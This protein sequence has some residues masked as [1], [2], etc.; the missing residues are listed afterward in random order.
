MSHR[1]LILKSSAILVVFFVVNLLAPVA[2]AQ[3]AIT[4][5]GHVKYSTGEPVAGATVT[6]TVRFNGS[7]ISSETTATDAGG[8]YVFQSS[9]SQSPCNPNEWFFQ[10]FIAEI[11]DDEALPLSNT[12]F[13]SGCA[14]PGTVTLGDLVIVRPRAITL[15]GVVRD[16]F[17]APVQGLTI[18]MTRTKYDFEPDVVTTATTTTDGSGHYQFD[19]WSRCTVVEDFRASIG[20]Y[21]F[22]GG[23]ATSGC[24]LNSNDSLDFTIDL[25]TLENA[26][27]GPC[28]RS[29]GRPV[30]V[31]NGNVFLQ[32]TDYQLPGIGESII[33]ARSYNSVSQIAGLF[34][35]SWSSIYDEKVSSTNGLL[36]LTMPDGRV[37]SSITP[38]F[39][40]QIAQNGDNTYTVTFKSGYVHRFNAIGKLISLTD[41]NGNQ[42]TLSYDATGKLASIADP[43]GR[44]VTVETNGNGRVLSLSDSMGTIASYSYGNNDELLSVRYG[45]NSG[46]Q[47]AYV[48]VPTGLALSSVTDVLG[49]VI[50]RHDYDTRGRAITSEAHTGVE[51]Y[52]LNYVSPT[53]TDVT[54]ALGRT[55]KF[56]YHNVKGTKAVTQVEG[57]CGCGG[58]QV[59]TWTYDDQL[60]ITSHTNAMGEVATYAYDASGN[61]INATGVLGSSSFTYNQFG[62][63]LTATDAM[64]GVTSNS[65]DAAGNLLSVTDALNN[66]TTFTYDVRGQLLTMNNALGK[67]TT[68]GY[69]PSGNISQV[70]DAVDSVTRF[71]YNSRGRLTSITDPLDNAT[72]Y[73]YDAADRVNK[74]ARPDGTFVAYTYDLAGRRTRFTDA[75]NNNT[76]FTY[77][78]AYRLIAVTDAALKSVSYTYDLMSNLTGA[79]DQLGRTT[80]VEYDEFNRPVKTIYPPVVTGAARLQG[81]VEYDA[82]GNVTKRTDATGRVITFTYDNANRIVSTTDP[83]LQVTSYEYNARSNVTA[84]VDALGQRYTFDYDD[85][86]RVTASTRAGMTMTFA[87]DGVGNLTLRTDYNNMPTTYSYDALNRLTGIDYPDSSPV[88]YAYDKLSRLISATNVNGTVTFV[89]DNLGRISSTT[90]VWGETLNY[91][92]DGNDR[93]TKIS[94]GATPNASYLYDAVNRITRI[95]DSSGKA[96]TNHLRCG[97]ATAFA[98]ATQQ[99]G[100]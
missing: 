54:D 79:T 65:Y 8:N 49:N 19:T 4:F 57:V 92:Y 97:R 78:G 33:V 16:Q 6:M 82:A 87:Y 89:Y 2:D 28:N 44:V 75:L 13:S 69:D 77:D 34:G 21:T 83:L 5:Q 11:I 68:V 86:G 53:E 15:G 25:G 61:Q 39:F 29:V 14:G 20:G 96:T 94:I 50:E 35:R 66:T 37:V 88:R 81:T 91:T 48:P 72:A 27:R 46:Y 42:T 1:S 60:N 70:T 73:T 31:A 43:F 10:A 67:V 84:V 51:R 17:G 62:Q 99:R 23:T 63:V 58:S 55:T 41:R 18:T 22:Q 85:L 9:R 74:I 98:R 47:F 30:N 95:T 32:Q 90:D 71:A 24:V 40:G 38:D 3:V 59:Q 80:N 7:T 36:Q 64:N 100:D 52:T 56:F 76:T 93:R 12:A 45:D 26:G